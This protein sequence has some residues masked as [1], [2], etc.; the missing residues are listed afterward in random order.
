MHNGRIA[1]TTGGSVKLSFYMSA[2]VET[3]SIFT[4]PAMG[5]LA[6]ILGYITFSTSCIALAWTETFN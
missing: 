1:V 4:A 5:S 6:Y 3:Y 2:V